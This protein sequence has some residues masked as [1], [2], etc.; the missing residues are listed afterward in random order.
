MGKKWIYSEF[1]QRS[2]FR[3]GHFTSHGTEVHRLFNDVHV[4]RYLFQVDGHEKESVV[5]F[6]GRVGMKRM[7]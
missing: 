5:I 1:I 6:P 7:L 2:I 4:P 3:P